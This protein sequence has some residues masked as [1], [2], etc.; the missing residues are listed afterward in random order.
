MRVILFIIMFCASNLFENRYRKCF[1][2]CCANTLPSFNKKY[3]NWKQKN[4]IEFSVIGIICFLTH[5]D[6][7]VG[8]LCQLKTATQE[9]L[10]L[11]M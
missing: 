8:Q 10:L 3:S 6:V 7:L 5:S 11:C 4:I 2:H 1:M 9:L